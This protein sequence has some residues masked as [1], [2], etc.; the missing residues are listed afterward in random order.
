M[1]SQWVWVVHQ[2]V[3]S[4]LFKGPLLLF[5]GKLELTLLASGDI[6]FILSLV[7]DW[8]KH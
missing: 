3:G 8:V 4:W 5:Q 7:P 6:W 1:L 2:I